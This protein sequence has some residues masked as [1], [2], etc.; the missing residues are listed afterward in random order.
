MQ[1]TPSPTASKD[2]PF[3]K[4]LVVINGAVPL[5]ILIFDA[6]RGQLG[7]NAVNFAIHTTGILSLLFLVLSLS[8][9]PL[10]RLTGWN[11]LVAFR[12]SLGL[13]A[14]F[15]A[16]I[17]VAIYVGFDRA[18]D[19]TSTMQEVLKRR[20]LQVGL[21]A[22][23]LMLPLAVTST[24]AMI[25]RI[26]GKRWKR[27]HRLA[28]LAAG[29]GVLHY[30]LLVKS[31]VRQP[32]A[33]AGVLAV[34]FLV[35]FA[36]HYLDLKK[37]A[38]R[39]SVA[40]PLAI[41][42]KFWAGELQVVAIFDETSEVRT[43]RL[44]TPTGGPLPFDYLP[45]QY[46]NLQLMIDGRRVSRSYTIASSPTRNGYCEVSVKR[47]DSGL[48]SLHL[49]RTLHPG[50]RLRISAPAGKFVFTGKE[51]ESVVLI[52]GGVGITPMMS[53]TRYLTDR[54][55]TGGIFLVIVAKT[56]GDIIFHDELQFLQ[57]RFPNLHLHITLTRVGADDVW[58]GHR[59]RLDAGWLKY[60]V[61]E[62]T[63]RRVYL[64]GPDDMMAATHEMLL[65]LGVAPANIHQEAFVSPG[66]ASS[67]RQVVPE[68]TVPFATGRNGAAADRSWN[69]AHKHGADLASATATFARSAKSAWLSVETTLLEASELAGVDLPF[70]CRSG[71][72]GQCK[73]KLLAGTVRMDVD[74]ALSSVEKGTGWVLACQSRCREDVTVD[75]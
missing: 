46:L 65:S 70:E 5:A 23:V 59:G 34:L 29:L 74:D 2:L 27:L 55:W 6:L 58:S 49:H 75:A 13:F 20:Y 38:Q 52:A 64:C 51:S 63:N 68:A 43:F 24:N 71:I 60:C 3:W 19:F 42:R 36:W 10:R 37:A 14:F 54:G 62:L 4:F 12:R 40:A 39:P 8:V 26:G 48:A 30:F 47:E 35:R 15:Y 18:L 72:C 31:D 56:P 22:V 73:V 61:A 7:A 33:F 67:P 50:D 57:Q 69:G 66:I 11:S 41:N 45:G 53:I 9:T 17:H 32:V 28:Y 25:S 44:M 16:V 21:M 1:P